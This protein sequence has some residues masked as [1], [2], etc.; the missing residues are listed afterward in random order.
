MISK[1]EFKRTLSDRLR[2]AR[3][4]R[5]WDQKTL[6]KEA[7]VSTSAICRIEAAKVMPSAYVAVALAY[8]VG[9]NIGTLLP[10]GTPRISR[11]QRA[12]H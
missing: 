5:G 3:E 1:S 10:A 11:R 2:L 9:V 6:A 12:G 8:A 4:A 7:G